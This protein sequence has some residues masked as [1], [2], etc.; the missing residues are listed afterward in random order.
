MELDDKLIKQK[1]D[2]V[3]DLPKNYEPNLETKW[4]LLATSLEQQKN[5]KKVF[6]LWTRIAAAASV[7]LISGI[8]MLLFQSTYNKT[9]ITTQKNPVLKPTNASTQTPP[10]VQSLAKQK[11]QT[12]LTK[13]ENSALKSADTIESIELVEDIK[14]QLPYYVEVTKPE[15][16]ETKRFIEIDFEEPVLSHQTSTETIVKATQFKFRFGSSQAN[17]RLNALQN[18]PNSLGL[19]ATF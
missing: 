7:V 2:S 6:V 3:V 16:K 17:Q 18:Q 4:D 13:N 8:L 11:K 14:V 1:I 5:Q 9:N 19:K 12:R 15:Q 10:M